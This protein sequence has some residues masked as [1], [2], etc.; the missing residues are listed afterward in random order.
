MIPKYFAVVSEV[1]TMA[2]LCSFELSIYGYSPML[3]NATGTEYIFMEFVQGTNL[4]DIW[5]DLGEVE[6]V[7]ISH[8][9]AELESKMMLIAFPACRSL[10]YTKDLENVARSASWPTRPGITLEDKCFCVG[11]DT[12]CV[13]GMAGDHSST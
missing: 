13:Y 8:Q 5:F 1:A 9:L 7:S 2:L 12:V 4:S 3:N 6:I 11:P 10:Y